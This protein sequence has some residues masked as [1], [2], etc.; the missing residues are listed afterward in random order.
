MIAI[1]SLRQPWKKRLQERAEKLALKQLE[2]EL[3]ETAER[4]REV[5]NLLSLSTALRMWSIWSCRRLNFL[6]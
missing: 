1:N 5:L 3:K 4:E 6:P 2:K